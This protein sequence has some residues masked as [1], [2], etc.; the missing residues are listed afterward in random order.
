M[1]PGNTS[2]VKTIKALL[3]RMRELFDIKRFYIVADRGM[4]NSDNI[5]FIE[6]PAH[7]HFIF[8][9]PPDEKRKRSPRTNSDLRRRYRVVHEEIDKTHGI[10]PLKVKEIYH[11]GSRY[12]VCLNDRKSRKDTINRCLVH[13]RFKRNDKAR[14][15]A[16]DRKQGIQKISEGGQRKCEY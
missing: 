4:M 3:E 6:D 15:K 13:Q 10:S 12:I 8:W 11:N 14:C 5:R 2:D 9:A 16:T 1:W 7:G